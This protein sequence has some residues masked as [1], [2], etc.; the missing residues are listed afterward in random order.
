VQ[1]ELAGP[2]DD[3]LIHPDRENVG[4]AEFLAFRAELEMLPVDLVRGHPPGRYPVV[5]CP[6]QHDHRQL[7]AD[8][9]D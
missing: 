8:C 3:V 9:R 2:G 7:F 4:Q 5:V 6:L 1:I